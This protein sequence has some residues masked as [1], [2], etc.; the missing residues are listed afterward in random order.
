[1][2][3][4][5]DRGSGIGDRGSEAGGR[6]D[7]AI[8]LAVREM[9][10]VEPPAGLRGRVLDRIDVLSTNPVAS[11]FLGAEALAKAARRKIWWIAGPIAAAAV[12]VLAVLAP[13]RQTAWRQTAPQVGPSASPSIAQVDP[14]PGP[15]PVT[16]Q[17]PQA[18]RTALNP[19]PPITPAVALSGSRPSPRGIEDRL[20]AAAVAPDVA[21]TT[22]ID[23]LAPIAPITV[24]GTHPADIAPREIA[25]SP[26]APIAELQIAPLS[27]PDR[28]N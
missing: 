22:A 18:P 9:L 2:S 6:L 1:M 27:P 17:S 16:S 14:A 21:G 7:L 26:L 19:A 24:A 13:W 3:N 11:A 4:I 20:V 8:D 10:D 23:P 5:G 25:I 28:R 12:I 15:P